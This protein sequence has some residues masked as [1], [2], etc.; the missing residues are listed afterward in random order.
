MKRVHGFSRID[1]DFW[2]IHN[3]SVIIRVI[4]G[5]LKNIKEQHE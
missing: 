5:L 2:P 1:T 4:R 3:C